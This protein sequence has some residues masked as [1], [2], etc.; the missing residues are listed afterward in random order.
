MLPAKV[1]VEKRAEFTP[2]ARS[3]R[4]GSGAAQLIA[5][6]HRVGGGAF[7]QKLAA[8]TPAGRQVGPAT[9][10]A[11][12]DTLIRRG[13]AAFAALAA[14]AAV[15][16]AGYDYQLLWVDG[17]VSTMPSGINE[18]GAVVGSYQLE[19]GPDLLI[20]PFTFKDGAYA[21]W[22][23]GDPASVSF[24]DVN[25]AR[26]LVSNVGHRDFTTQAFFRDERGKTLLA[27][28]GAVATHAYGLNDRDVVVGAY[29][30]DP[31]PLGI[32]TTSAFAWTADQGF[33]TFDAPGAAGLTIAW[34]VGRAGTVVGVYMDARSTYHGFI[35]TPDG[36][37][38]TV[39]YPGSPYTQLMGLN[40]R[41]DVVG[42]YQDPDDL[43]LKGFVLRGGRFEPVAPAGAAN[44][45]Y[46]YR[47]TDD[48]RIVGWYMDA[49]WRTI[50]F[51]ATPAAR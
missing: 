38:R 14:T 25:D 28:P 50:G 8:G 22:P 1:P 16:A 42:F 26:H 51:L 19:R 43:V 15:H 17:G 3:R 35:R 6:L 47:I 34:G 4:T 11:M 21:A 13:A 7:R 44:G 32:L 2:S 46:P 41:G 10:D 40:G 49:H 20:R 29:E 5:G 12:R 30:H 23:E 27:V 45:S 48:G 33:R 37:V 18:S 24:D 31:D 39:D 36:A 9:G